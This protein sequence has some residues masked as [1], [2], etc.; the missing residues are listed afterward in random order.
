MEWGD[1]D[2]LLVDAPPGTSDEHISISQYL[3][4]AG[5]DGALIVTTPQEM[6]L[7]DVRK[8][9]T[10]WCGEHF[11]HSVRMPSVAIAVPFSSHAIICLTA[12]SSPPSSC[13]HKVG[14]PVLGV[15]EN[16]AGFICPTCEHKSDIFPAVTG[17]AAAMCVEMHAAFLGSLPLDPN[18][19]QS[20]EDG[21][22][23]IERHPQSAAAEPLKQLVHSR[24]Q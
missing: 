4:K 8:E 9:V 1:L 12:L 5:V 16:M 23:F 21:K 2:F 24:L 19:L 14:V 7:L 3:T 10:F 6:A 13:S 18:L 20:C 17:G 11:I 22:C 15:V